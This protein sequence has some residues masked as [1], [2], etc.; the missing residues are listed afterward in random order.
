MGDIIVII[1]QL[2]E[3]IIQLIIQIIEAILG[4]FA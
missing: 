1:S 3:A 2:I 4:I